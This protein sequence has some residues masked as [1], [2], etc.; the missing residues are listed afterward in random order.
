MIEKLPTLAKEGQEH[1]ACVVDKLN[2]VIDVVNLLT[3]AS[4]THEMIKPK[5]DHKWYPHGENFSKYRC[6]ICG[7]EK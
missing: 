1:D 5:C 2:E 3:K 7:E 4:I 6:S